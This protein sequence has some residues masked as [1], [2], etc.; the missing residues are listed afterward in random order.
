MAKTKIQEAARRRR[1]D[2]AAEVLYIYAEPRGTSSIL[3]P[4]EWEKLSKKERDHYRMMA[5]ST[6]KAFN[7]L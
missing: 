7:G 3:I 2:R 1:L 4:S 6:V 5:E